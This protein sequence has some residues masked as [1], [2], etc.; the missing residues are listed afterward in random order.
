MHP[1]ATMCRVLGV[2]YN[3]ISAC[4]EAQSR[5][6]QLEGVWAEQG[7]GGAGCDAP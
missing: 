2:L 4:R 3:V 1:I 5:V 6:R 7:R